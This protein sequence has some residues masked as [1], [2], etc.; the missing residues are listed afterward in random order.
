VLQRDKNPK[1]RVSRMSNSIVQ[2][3]RDEY[4]HAS[5]LVSLETCLSRGDLSKEM[6]SLAHEINEA[7][8]AHTA[9]DQ[10]YMDDR[11]LQD[12]RQEINERLG[13][14]NRGIDDVRER[15]LRLEHRGAS[16]TG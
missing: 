13:S 14:I 12:W 5:Y 15:M 7:L 4:W 1:I 3:Y 10:R 9:S 16:C 6:E 11:A 8:R 2:G